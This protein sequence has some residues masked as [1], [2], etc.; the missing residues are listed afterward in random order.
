MSI[1]LFDECY[2]RAHEARRSAETTS[3]PSQKTHFLELEQRWLRAAASVTPKNERETKSPMAQPKI[4]TK[5]LGRRPTKFT[6]ERI[7]QIK[8]LVAS[9]K[10]RHEIAASVGVTIGSLQVTCSKLGISLRRPRLNPQLNPQL[11][12]PRHEVPFRRGPISSPTK[13]SSV[14]FAFEQIDELLQ[15]TQEKDVAAPRQDETEHQQAD[16]ANLALTMHYRGLERAIPLRLSNELIGKLVLEAQLR[17]MSLG[18]LVGAIVEGA[19]AA[20]L[21]SLLDGE[22]LRLDASVVPRDARAAHL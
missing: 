7:E 15:G 17:E 1:S 8:N 3:M 21:S 2:R 4:A 9:G 10:T 19:V 20:G 5:V 18:Q 22:P 13:V 11:N 12:L 6:P 16:N 14:D